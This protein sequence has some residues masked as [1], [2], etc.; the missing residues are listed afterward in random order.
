VTEHPAG[1][2]EE[3]VVVSATA[4]YRELIERIQQRVR[5]SQAR[6]VRTLNAELV[7]LYW[8]IG[9]DILVAQAASGWGD[10]VVGRIAE[11]LRA[12][13]GGARGFSRRNVFYM[14]RF[15]QIWA[16]ADLVQPLA[17]QIGWSHHLVLMDTCSDRRDVYLWYAAKAAAGRWSRRHLEAQL[18]ERQATF[19]VS[20]R[21]RNRGLTPCGRLYVARIRR[22]FALG[23]Q[24]RPPGC[25]WR[26]SGPNSSRQI[27][28]ARPA[29]ASS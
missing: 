14:R 3:F 12:T 18:V 19:A 20:T 7:M 6:A 1:R 23:A 9:R 24:L 17:A 4:G 5:E 15:A 11:D 16:E 28:T 22:G 2:G 10:D 25:G 26:L 27:T 13:T 8:S 29:S 21:T